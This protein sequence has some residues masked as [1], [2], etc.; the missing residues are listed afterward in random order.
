[1]NELKD[2]L[3]GE[4]DAQERRDLEAR[5]QADPALRLELD[6]L[7]VTQGALLSV[8]DEELPRR[9][10]FVSDQVFETPWWK[11][12]LQPAAVAALCAS[13]V[14]HGWLTRG[15]SNG[16][17][18]EAQVNARIEKAVSEVRAEA[19][20]R[21]ANMVDAM[22]KTLEYWQKRTLRYERASY[23]EGRQ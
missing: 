22:E 9:I 13:I 10:A 7:S 5:L 20:K 1:M 15:A 14:L 23:E 3:L 21:E 19:D 8:R 12:W 6:R 17:V 4:L 16:G 11:R 18:T 2:Y